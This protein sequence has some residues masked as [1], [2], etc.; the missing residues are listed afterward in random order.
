MRLFLVTSPAVAK[1]G[2][3][4]ICARPGAHPN[5]QALAYTHSTLL[6]EQQSPR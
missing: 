4:P 2:R 5:V 3:H 6:T 1:L